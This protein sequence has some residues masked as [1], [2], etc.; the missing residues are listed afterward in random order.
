MA[1]AT[2]GPEFIWIIHPFL[3]NLR[4]ILVNFRPMGVPDDLGK[5]EIYS[6]I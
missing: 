5:S 1:I 6:M 3:T 4:Q 2:F